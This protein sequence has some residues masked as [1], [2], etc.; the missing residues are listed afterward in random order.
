LTTTPLPRCRVGTSA[1]E[2]SRLSLGS[3][4]TY[5]R[6]QFADAVEMVRAAVTAGITL[7]D[8]GVYGRR[9]A[10]P[11]FTDVLWGAIMRAT[12]I[13]RAD[14]LVS[15][16]L[17]IEEFD[18]AG[19]RPQLEYGFLRAGYEVADLV[20]L[21][22]LRRDDVRLEDLVDDLAALTRDGLIRAWGV[23][24]WSAGDIRRLREIAAARG[25]AG[26]QIAQLKYS[27]ARR[28]IADG[29][30][31]ARL[32]AEGFSLQASD[33]LEGG[34]LAGRTELTR[35]IGRDPGGV[36]DAIVRA[37]AGVAALAE[38]LGTT[39]A[40]LAVAFTLTHPAN[41]S[42]LFGATRLQQLQDN[43]AAVDLVDRIGAEELRA[44][45]EPFWV[46]RGVVDPEGP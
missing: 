43:L 4:H 14:Y 29:E 46:D 1:L 38:E 8:V 41:A 13:P 30:P 5:D 36:R 2:V 25:V 20:V 24:N 16:K 26:P 6:M 28:A 35:E 19:F 9:G 34:L 21:G 33:V 22:D 31:F 10:A 44:L 37:A 39:P 11:V 17:W 32:F 18:D 12:G 42:T 7:F 15:A 23:N 27:V 3:W 40:R 45:V